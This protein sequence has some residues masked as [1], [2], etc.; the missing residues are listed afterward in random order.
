M[1]MLYGRRLE[2]HA[3]LHHATV[4]DQPAV[5]GEASQTSVFDIR[6]PTR[7]ILG[8]QMRSPEALCQRRRRRKCS[9]QD[10]V[11]HPSD[12][13]RRSSSGFASFPIRIAKMSATDTLLLAR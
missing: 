6:V 7:E 13:A 12:A 5:P 3:L 8:V 10:G 1:G 11:K 4:V 2:C 9:R